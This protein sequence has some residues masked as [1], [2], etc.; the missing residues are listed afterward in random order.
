MKYMTDVLDGVHIAF[1]VNAAT[2]SGAVD[3]VVVQRSD[4]TFACTPFHARFGKLQIIRA[5]GTEVSVHINGELSA[6]KMRLGAAGEAYFFEEELENENESKRF[7]SGDADS[8][9]GDD[10]PSIS[11]TQSAPDLDAA[12]LQ[13]SEIDG[14]TFLQKLDAAKQDSI[15]ENEDEKVIDSNVNIPIRSISDGNIRMVETQENLEWHWGKLPRVSSRDSLLL[16][17]NLP[18]K[19]NLEDSKINLDDPNPILNDSN[20]ISNDSKV[21]EIILNDRKL[22]LDDSKAVKIGLEEKSLRWRDLGHTIQKYW[23]QELDPSQI[24]EMIEISDCANLLEKV[25]D[26]NQNEA[27]DIFEMRKISFDDFNSNPSILFSP[28]LVVK[29]E[30]D[31]FPFSVAG[32]FLCSFIF[33]RRGLD[34][35]VL[36]DLEHDH[37]LMS[38]AVRRK[39]A[40]FPP[41]SEGEEKEKREEKKELESSESAQSAPGWFN[42]RRWIWSS[43]NATKTST[44]EEESGEK[45][46]EKQSSDSNTYYY[47]ED[48]DEEYDSFEEVSETPLCPS[49]EQLKLL[50]LTSGANQVLFSVRTGLRGVQTLSC[51]LFLWQENV[52]IVISD[53]DGT[54]TRSDVP[55]QFLP[56]M[57]RDWSQKGV[58]ELFTRIQRNGYNILYLTARSIGQANSTRGFITS[59]TQGGSS[60]PN[61]PVFMSPD[62]LLKALNREVIERRPEEFKIQCLESLK[63]CYPPHFNPYTAGFGNR[64]SDVNSY[65]AVGIPRE[66]IFVIN[67]SGAVTTFNLTSKRTYDHLSTLVAHMFPRKGDHSV[68]HN[69]SASNYWRD[70]ALDWAFDDDDVLKK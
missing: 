49:S 43:S 62:R 54:I 12:A 35:A 25:S 52:P 57:G 51:Q 58:A 65:T 19:I 20:P 46:G 1:G 10:R 67:P 60:L 56:Y 15:E 53:V 18:P 32:P 50:N 37:P 34:D 9:P 17:S 22:V 64:P 31:I 5:K 47:D 11:L 38:P 48:D 4:G 59:L 3:I 61:G 36:Q 40:T 24:Q 14:K 13:R 6:L 27:R 2:L 8:D 26:D 66:R 44:L 42:Y 16:E 23:S 69:F 28:N 68:P 33:Y 70:P 7:L 45:N 29:I 39:E 41:L 55:G 30:N 63:S 21:S